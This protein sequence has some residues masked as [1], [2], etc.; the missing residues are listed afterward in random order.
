M[1]LKPYKNNILLAL[2]EKKQIAVG[3]KPLLAD[4]GQVIAVGEEVKDIKVGDI[5]VVRK[6]GLIDVDIDGSVYIFVPDT[7]KFII[8][9][10]EDIVF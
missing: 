3:E 5:I 9:K 8:S 4:Y 6:W 1:I 2:K 10:L 7:D